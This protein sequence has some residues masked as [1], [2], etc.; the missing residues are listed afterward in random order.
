MRRIVRPSAAAPPSH[1]PHGNGMAGGERDGKAPGSPAAWLPTSLP[2]SGR[3]RVLL[4]DDDGDLRAC[5]GTVLQETCAVS[6]VADGAAALAELRR[7]PYDLLLTD[8]LMPRLDGFA[9]LR[10]VRSD[11]ALATLPVIVLSGRDGEESRIEG[12]E[13]GADDYLV[14]P[15]SGR[16]LAARVK[17]HVALARLRKEVAERQSQA[18]ADAEIQ[19]L[20]DRLHARHVP[21]R[22]E[23]KVPSPEGMIVGQSAAIREMLA[24]AEQV[25][26]TPSTVLLSGETGTGKELLAQAIHARSPR[27]ALPMVTLCGAALPATLV[28][29]ELFGRE[30]GAYTGA[31]TRQ[32]GRF[33]LADGSTLFLD[34]VGELPLEVQAKLLRVLQ[35]GQ[36]ERLGGTRTL[37]ADV[38]VIAATNRDLEKAVREG[39]FRED[40]FYRLNVFPIRVPPLRERPEDIP[41]LVWAFI[42]EF[43]RSMGK[44]IDSVPRPAMDA[45]QRHP[46]PGNVRELRNVVERAMIVA[47]GPVLQI[48]P[49]PPGPATGVPAAEGLTLAEVE[50]R[51]ILVVLEQTGWRVSG[52]RG[53]A[54]RLGLKPTTLEYRMTKLGIRRGG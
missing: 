42:R 22:A 2:D 17:A 23:I 51:H 9:L 19:R 38:R 26:Q 5:V 7:A 53:A 44:A 11:P 52:R 39:Q 34:E 6:T 27:H 14:K 24:Q 20:Q 43:G 33:E 3:P 36:F 10:A 47:R 50:R 41:L 37:R 15:F 1:D 4:A 35:G 30:K 18:A 12:L 8:I 40:L 45:L 16:E 28:E 49:P 48:D 13:S 29:S 54:E 46:W 32:L 25:A 31:L 21:P